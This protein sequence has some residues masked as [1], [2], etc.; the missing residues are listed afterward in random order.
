[1][2]RFVELS[3]ATDRSIVWTAPE[4]TVSQCQWDNA[5]A[6][7]GAADRPRS[8]MAM[9]LTGVSGDAGNA[10]AN[11]LTPEKPSIALPYR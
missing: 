8:P 9:K 7:P 11:D 4:K 1:M 3:R 5:R 2:Y 6:I 10:D